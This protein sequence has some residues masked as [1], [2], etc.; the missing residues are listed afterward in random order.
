MAKYENLKDITR[1]TVGTEQAAYYLNRKATT[2]RNWA[3]KKETAPIL[4]IMMN[5]R[6]AWSVEKIRELIGGENGRHNS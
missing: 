2:L 6:M 5:G 1:P 4:P 3:Y